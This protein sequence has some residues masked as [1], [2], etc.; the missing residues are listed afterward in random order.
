MQH[1]L[2]FVSSPNIILVIIFMRIT[3]ALL[4]VMTELI[5]TMATYINVIC[6]VA[7]DSSISAIFFSFDACSMVRCGVV[8]H[9]HFGS[10][11][12]LL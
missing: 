2:K 9:V 1:D 4:I 3:I 5:L 7:F 12:A 8:S 11:L 6:F 10:S